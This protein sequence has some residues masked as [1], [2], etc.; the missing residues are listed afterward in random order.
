M[1]KIKGWRNWG[2][3]ERARDFGQA[4]MGG[5]ATGPPKKYAYYD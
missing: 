3:H 5:G 2:P 4:L 1:N